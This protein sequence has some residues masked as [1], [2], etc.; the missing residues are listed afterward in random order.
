MLADGA[1]AILP[2]ADMI[3]IGVERSRLEREL[4]E[5]EQER[6][7]AE[8]QLGN[9]SFVSRAPEQVVT[10]QRDRLARSTEQIAIIRKR[11]DALDA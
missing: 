4:E 5:A 6:Q 11:L 9:E 1:V 10:V 2:L 3:D 8:R 7:R